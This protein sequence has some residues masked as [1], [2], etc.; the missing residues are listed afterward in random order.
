MD[1][2]RVES[3][4][5]APTD[6]QSLSPPV[7]LSRTGQIHVSDQGPSKQI[8]HQFPLAGFKIQIVLSPLR[9]RTNCVITGYCSNIQMTLGSGGAGEVRRHRWLRT[10]PLMR[11]GT[12]YKIA[13][14]VRTGRRERASR[15]PD[16]PTRRLFIYPVNGLY[17]LDRG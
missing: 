6:H 14:L 16:F 17:V 7:I 9:L 10:R 13:L 11:R 15:T 4:K 12:Q 3:F 5:S 8:H 2:Q 1:K